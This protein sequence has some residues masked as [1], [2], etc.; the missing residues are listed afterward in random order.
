MV[1]TVRTALRLQAEMAADVL[2]KAARA[3]VE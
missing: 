1:A 2:P 3:T